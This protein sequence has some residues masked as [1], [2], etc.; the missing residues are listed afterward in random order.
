MKSVWAELG[1]EI[2]KNER[3]KIREE[4]REEGIGIGVEKG[5]GIGREEGI[6]IGRLETMKE[7]AANM[8]AEGW[9]DETIAKILRVDVADVRIWLDSDA[10]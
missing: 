10:E 6:G 9:S 7:S 8:R 1:E 5:I 4:G 3:E 2:A